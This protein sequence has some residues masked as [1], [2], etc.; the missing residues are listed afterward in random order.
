M[1]DLVAFRKEF[2]DRYGKTP[3]IFSAPGRVNIIGEHTDYNDGF[4]LPIAIDRR[5]YVAC[6]PRGNRKVRVHSKNLNDCAEFELDD[7]QPPPKQSWFAHIFGI[8]QTLAHLRVSM[9]GADL[10]IESEVPIGS[11]LSSSAAL[12]ISAGQA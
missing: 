3:R 8:A 7:P 6:A 4:V 11:G 12:E 5:T 10:L 9:S 1:I 2:S